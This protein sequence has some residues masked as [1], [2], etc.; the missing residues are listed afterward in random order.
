MPD[1]PNPALEAE[2]IRRMAAE[3]VKLALRPSEVEAVR[4]T[5][6]GLLEE[7]G[8]IAPSDRAGVEP[9]TSIMVEEWQ[10]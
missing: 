1:V 6:N 3:E 2:T 8:W 9:E 7:I 10:R 5:L 4:T